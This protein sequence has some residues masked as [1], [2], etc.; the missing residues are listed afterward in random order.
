MK[1]KSKKRWRWVVLSIPIFLLLL[2]IG[3]VAYF[4]WDLT[5]QSVLLG[6]TVIKEY[7]PELPPKEFKQ[8]AWPT[9]PEPGASI[10]ELKFPT[11]ELN[12]PV[13]QGTH[14]EELKLGAGHFAGSAL[15]GQGGNVILSGH[16][17][18]VFKKLEGLQLGEQVTF[19]TPYGDFV[20]E[21][22]DFK[23]VPANDQTVMVPTDYE[24]LTLTTCYPFDFIGDAPDRYIVYTKLVSQPTI[25]Q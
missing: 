6:H 10:G 11:I 8:A 15:P 16:R 9:L 23:I 20:Y 13:V 19:T 22:I 12:V 7:E 4:G 1:K 18:T 2:G 25:T 5:K 17:E 14:E 21:T 24:T 3:I